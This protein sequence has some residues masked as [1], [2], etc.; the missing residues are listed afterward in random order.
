MASTTVNE[1]PR[2]VALWSEAV[3]ITRLDSHTYSAN[4]SPSFL[5]GTG[6]VLPTMKRI[7][8][9]VLL[10]NSLDSQSQTADIL[11]P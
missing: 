7:Q 10:T 3:K 5:I 1:I 2:G 8:E 9:F 4:I 6:K 11:P